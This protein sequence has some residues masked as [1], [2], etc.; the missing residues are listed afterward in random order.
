MQCCTVHTSVGGPILPT[1]G[2]VTKLGTKKTGNHLA[3]KA[4]PGLNAA[5]IL[6]DPTGNRS[7][8]TKSAQHPPKEDGKEIDRA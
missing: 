4:A 2:N 6:L 8:L 5:N 1:K 3:N 7:M